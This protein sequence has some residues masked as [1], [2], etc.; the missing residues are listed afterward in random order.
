M[1]YVEETRRLIARYDIHARKR[2]G[3]N[4]LIDNHVLDKIIAA[5]DVCRDDFIL[6]IG[7]GV[8][9]MTRALC[10]H[11][12]R[13][14]AVEIDYDLVDIL[15]R[16]LVPIYDNLEIR[17]GDILKMDIGEIAE[18]NNAG[19]P[20]KVVANLPYYITTPII[21]ELLENHAPI[22]SITVM[23]QR[24]VAERMMAEPGSRDCGAVSLAVSYYATASLEANVPANCFIPR[25]HVDSAVIR[26]NIRENP[27][28][29]TDDENLMFKLIRA[30]FGERRKTLAN[31][32]TNSPE[33]NFSK[34]E[35]NQT[36]SL[37][38]IDP[39]IRGEKLGLDDYAR[40]ADFFSKK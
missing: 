40:L 33:L 6:E 15:E 17:E 23:V 1:N 24:E 18:N 14:L 5:A 26:L 4:F 27:P 22:Q 30:G 39:G 11:A 36:I 34:E 8:G 12:G 20:I 38:G 10:E 3:Q 13:V 37:A 19:K 7:P 31:A 16:E 21:M 25:P 9:T 32:I 29:L 2:F 35:V 28:V